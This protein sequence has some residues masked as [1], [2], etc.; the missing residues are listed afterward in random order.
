MIVIARKRKR[1]LSK[2]E[3]VEK[4]HSRTSGASLSA[5]LP[6]GGEWNGLIAAIL[7]SYVCTPYIARRSGAGSV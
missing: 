4:W 6:I 1:N 7:V 3:E 2:C 5:L